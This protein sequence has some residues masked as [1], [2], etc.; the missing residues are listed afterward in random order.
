MKITVESLASFVKCK[1]IEY[2]VATLPNLQK[3][4]E[5]AVNSIDFSDDGKLLVAAGDDRSIRIQTIT[6]LTCV[7]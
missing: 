5:C 4:S 6:D 3:S 7:L 1:N 2:T